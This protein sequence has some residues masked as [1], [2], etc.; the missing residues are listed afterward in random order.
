[1]K[2][3]TELLMGSAMMLSYTAFTG[4]MFC[5]SKIQNECTFMELKLPWLA[6]FLLAVYYVNYI[7]AAKGLSLSV[8]TGL[9]LVFAAAGTFVCV[10]SAALD[11]GGTGTKVVISIIYAC[12]VFASAFLAME[13]VK[14]KGLVLAFDIVVILAVIL[15]LFD[16]FIQ[17]L[18]VRSVLV[19][20]FVSISLTLVALI[21]S[22]V[23]R[24]D[25]SGAVKGDPSAGRLLI[26]GVFIVMAAVTVLIALFASDGVRSISQACLTALNWCVGAVKAAAS[27][28]LDLIEKLIMLLPSSDEM[29]VDIEMSGAAMGGGDVIYETGE[30]HLPAYVGYIAGAVL[31]A[32]VIYVLF[33]LRR[34]RAARRTVVRRRVRRV[35]AVR[36][37]GMGDALRRLFR[38]MSRALRY[39]VNCLRCRKTAPGLLAWCERRTRK[40]QR[41]R[42][43]ESG[44]QFLLRLSRG[45]LSDEQRQA[46][47][48]LAGLVER[49]FYSPRQA[50]VPPEIY[51]TVRSCRFV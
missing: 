49:S 6:V 33:R 12:E 27:F 4:W 45:E 10:H 31:V 19:M 51:K 39:K 3:S 26:L 20:C 47:S 41:R 14:P 21:A 32:V 40:T 5:L 16:H 46:L 22:R 24:E 8:Y 15:L 43:S 7:L 18:T 38:A 36:E 48:I 2:R 17:L 25:S 34:E 23:E 37:S 42:E 28:L 44:E 50:A 35:P 13:P 30:V 11:P 29:P 1:M 9:Q